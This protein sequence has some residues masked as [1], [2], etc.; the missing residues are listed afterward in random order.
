MLSANHIPGKIIET[1]P[2]IILIFSTATCGK[3]NN[4]YT[5]E[6]TETKE[7]KYYMKS[8]MIDN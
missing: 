4:L 1:L 8:Y 5:E 3:N 7:F 6:K 2:F